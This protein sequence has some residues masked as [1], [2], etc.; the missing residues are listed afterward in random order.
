M[1]IGEIQHDGPLSWSDEEMNSHKIMK[2][3][4]GGWFLHTFPLLIGKRRIMP[5]KRLT[6][7]VLQ[8]RIPQNTRS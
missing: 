6:N 7:A 3:P 4:P 8:D 2:H 5:L 1:F